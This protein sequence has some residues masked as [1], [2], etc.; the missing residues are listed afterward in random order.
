MDIYM[1]LRAPKLSQAILPSLNLL[2]S[3]FSLDPPPLPTLPTSNNAI[4]TLY[5]LLNLNTCHPEE[6]KKIKLQNKQQTTAIKSVK[7]RG[8]P[9]AAKQNRQ[10]NHNKIAKIYFGLLAREA[11][12]FTPCSKYI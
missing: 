7:I 6:V 9:T 3:K 4:V 2:I 8:Y 12:S 10:G 11:M 1:S 5:E